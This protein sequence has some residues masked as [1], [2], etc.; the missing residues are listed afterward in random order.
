MTLTIHPPL[1]TMATAE[2]ALPVYLQTLKQSE[3]LGEE[4]LADQQQIVELDARR[5]TN[6]QAVRAV[7]DEKK[8]KK[9]WCLMGSEFVKVEKGVL[10]AWLR[11]DQGVLDKEINSLRDGMKDKVS[12]LKR[13]EGKEIPRGFYLNA[14]SK[15][16]LSNIASTDGRISE[17]YVD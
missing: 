7:V 12:D 10:E 15:G 3:S 14:M 5:Q 13:L 17:R 4:I 11:N 6:R 16:D 8:E 1:A 2:R 9:M